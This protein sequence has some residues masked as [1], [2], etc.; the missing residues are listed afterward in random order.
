MKRIL[1]LALCLIC[2]TETIRAKELP[3]AYRDKS[4]GLV[5]P[6]TLGTLSFGGVHQYKKS[7]LG[8]SVRYSDK[9]LTK[10]DIYIYNRGI[11]LIPNGCNNRVVKSE[12]ESVNALLQT[13]QKLG[14]YKDLVSLN[15]GI[16]P[17]QGDIKF[18]WLRFEY[19]QIKN[20][21]SPEKLISDRL[22]TGF[23]NKFV[24]IS[25]TY[26]KANKKAGQKILVKLV[27]DLIK[28]LDKLKVDK[29]AHTT[30][31]LHAIET[32]AT[33]PLSKSGTIAMAKIVTFAQTSDTVLVT[34]TPEYC[35]WIMNQQIKQKHVLLAAYIA[36]N[37]KPQIEQHKAKNHA[38]E[39]VIYLLSVYKK[40]RQQASIR[41][42]ESI[43]NMIELKNNGK[44]K[45]YIK[46]SEVKK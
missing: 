21:P 12:A 8:Y 34:I 3:V 33:A 4:L 23:A 45:Q 13:M 37:I 38:Y 6:V 2:C 17:T 14:Y 27:G 22:I 30:P 15:T 35:P 36:G 42:V 9:E 46:K 44:L 43:E 29:K 5:F 39:G 28:I 31:I 11:S 16:M 18:I 32:F 40:L 26:K 7:A 24:K 41:R 19:R 25:L 1:L 10:A 20:S